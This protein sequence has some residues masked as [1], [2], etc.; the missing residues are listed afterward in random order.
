MSLVV[1]ESTDLE[2]LLERAVLRGLEMHATKHG[3]SSFT[4][5]EADLTADEVGRLLFPGQR[6]PK[7]SVYAL[8]KNGVL[9]ATKRGKVWYFTAPDV[10]A[11]QA[12]NGIHVHIPT[13]R[14]LRRR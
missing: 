8:R 9:L 1:M 3:A 11:F 13:K 12:Q 6:D 7:Q 10:R 2:R 4:P 14:D 5:L